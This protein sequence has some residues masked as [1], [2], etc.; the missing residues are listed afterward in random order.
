MA[1]A[2]ALDTPFDFAQQGSADVSGGACNILFFDD[3]I[4]SS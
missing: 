1:V 2:V 3:M 4:L